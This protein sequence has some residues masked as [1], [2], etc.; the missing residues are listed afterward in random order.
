MGESQD[1]GFRLLPLGVYSLDARV[2]LIHRAQRSLDLQYYY[3]ADD[4]SGRLILDQLM[5]AAARGVRVRLLIDDLH[6]AEVDGLLHALAG[7]PNFEVRLFNPFCCGRSHLATRVASSL[8]DISRIDHRM[9]NKL[10]VA[11]EAMAI[12]GGRNIADEYFT[13]NPLQN[14]VD[15]DVL[16]AGPVVSQLAASFL[17]YWDSEPAYDITI[18][19]GGDADS[20]TLAGV[21]AHLSGADG[22]GML[23]NLPPFDVLGYEPIGHELDAGRVAF[24]SGPAHAH[25]DPPEKVQ[26]HE[27]EWIDA[28]SVL[29]RMRILMAEAK[30]EVVL[31]SPY[32]VPR[33]R[34][35]EMLRALHERGVKV[36]ILTNS[37][38]ANDSGI[39]H[40]G[41]A[42]YRPDL[43]RYGVD[44][45]ELSPGPTFG[46]KQINPGSKPSSS[47]SLH[48]KLAVIDR[49]MVLVGSA[50][51]DP[52]SADENTEL[53][54]AVDSPALAR[55][56]LHVINISRLQSAYRVRFGADGKTLEWLSF[57][58]GD[59]KV[60][61]EE[62]ESTFWSRI[63][64]W[65]LA[66]L[67]PEKLL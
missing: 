54:V 24:T 44:L 13:R 50:N 46:S 19:H 22:D 39:V 67:I 58:E 33:A 43:L 37:L 47:G 51:L 38:A 53:G 11:D 45:Y 8:F 61:I 36:V 2:Q 27:Q 63:S 62:P 30:R 23:A 42:R 49:S 9:H 12:V 7:L 1:S 28:N 21:K 35:V 15:M 66:P 4:S 32:L 18:L 16:I 55:E 10:L 57:S 17:R 31:T 64:T 20:E 52:R 65:L 59:E 29:G 25:A 48:A 14:F 3:L 34:G 41:Y 56:L 40:T 26:P 5:R 6:T 60:F